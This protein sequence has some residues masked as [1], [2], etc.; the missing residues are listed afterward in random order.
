LRIELA[1]QLIDAGIQ[2]LRER[3][4]AA[5]GTDFHAT[6]RRR[7]VEIEFTVIQLAHLGQPFTQCIQARCLGLQLTELGG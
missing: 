5:T 6:H 7:L 1:G 3:V 2:R 4:R